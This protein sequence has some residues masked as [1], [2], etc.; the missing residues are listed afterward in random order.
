MKGGTLCHEETEQDQLDK[1]QEQ[2][3]DWVWEEGVE[4]GGAW[5]AIGLVQ[6]RQAT[7]CALIAARKSPIRQAN[8][9]II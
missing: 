8:R 9:V 5:A 7:A 3:E 4:A 6:V 2:G 1:D